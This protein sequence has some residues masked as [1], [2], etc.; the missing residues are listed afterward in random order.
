MKRTKKK[1][2]MLLAGLLTMM[3]VFT[4]WSPSMVYADD[5]S[6][7]ITTDD[8]PNRI[9]YNT[10]LGKLGIT[11]QEF[12]V[13]KA[14]EVTTLR[15]SPGSAHVDLT[16]ME[17]LSNLESFSTY[18]DSDDS[19]G[20]SKITGTEA[21]AGMENL[22]S[23]SFTAASIESLSGLPNNIE[24]LQLDRCD[25][26]ILP[27]LSQ[28]KNLK[29]LQLSGKFT[30]I[31]SA[32]EEVLKLTNLESLTV[33]GSKISKMSNISALS[34]LTNLKRLAIYAAGIT[35]VS[36]FASLTG[37]ETLDL[38]SNQISDVSA[39]AGLTNL[40]TLDL[41]YNNITN[42]RAL[43]ALEDNGTTVIKSNQTITVNGSVT[44]NGS[45]TS[46]TMQTIDD[47]YST[48]TSEQQ[49]AIDNVSDTNVE[50]QK[51][52]I[53][54]T[55][56]VDVSAVKYYK[57]L[58]VLLPSGTDIS[59]GVPITLKDS[60]IK[61]GMTIVMLHLKADGT[62]ENIPVTV[63]DGAVTG[64]FTSLSSVYY[65]VVEGSTGTGSG[66]G[67]VEGTGSVSVSTKY[68]PVDITFTG[69]NG[70]AMRWIS[71]EKDGNISISGLQTVIADGAKFNAE[72]VK[73]TAIANAVAEAKG[74]VPYVAYD[75]TLTVDGE[76]VT[77][78]AEHVDVS[79]PVPDGFDLGEGQ[80][81]TVYYYNNGKLEKCNTAVSDGFVTFGTTH[82]STFVYVQESAA[83]A[84]ATPAVSY[85]VSPKTGD[86]SMVSVMAVLA[87]AAVGSMVY[88][89]NKRRSY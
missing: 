76:E 67:S 2:Q 65:F 39:L 87:V 22:K 3:M 68:E 79:M 64:T 57:L 11:S 72:K 82:F 88:C 66:S 85:T 16:G 49:T 48:L 40:K 84:A 74:D 31:D 59:A 55:A 38:K 32:M 73:S 86:S 62:W 29:V 61:A 14:K 71:S 20:F 33:S 13:A 56:G 30:D 28:M 52:L 1:C 80:T 36:A 26:G 41:R 12:T 7:L 6:K 58:D 17:V 70:K 45:E 63:S 47:V 4:M 27:E 75:F 23:V 21:L 25:V 19:R 77:T 5:D 81:V 83:S 53:K 50:K 15:L 54:K 42:F 51:E 35:D 78:F 24:S 34:G 10:I 18:T 9:L 69:N 46:V 37:L 89:L 43:Q 8:I 60:S 44:V